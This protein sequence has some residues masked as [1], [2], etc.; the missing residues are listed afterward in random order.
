MQRN[1]ALKTIDDAF[2]GEECV[3]EEKFQFLWRAFLEDGDAQDEIE[4]IDS[5]K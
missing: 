2:A 3:D 4:S 1:E 5:D